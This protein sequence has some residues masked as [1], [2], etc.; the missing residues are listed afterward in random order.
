M[1]VHTRLLLSQSRVTSALQQHS[2]AGA[3]TFWVR[4]CSDGSARASS[5]LVSASSSRAAAL[6]AASRAR[7]SYGS[8]ASTAEGG[9]LLHGSDNAGNTQCME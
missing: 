7:S 8:A 4:L 5:A 1:Y 9:A 3:A 6:N 2:Y